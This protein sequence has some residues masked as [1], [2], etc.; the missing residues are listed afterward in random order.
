MNSFAALAAVAARAI[1][2]A[3]VLFVA[4]TDVDAA[5]RPNIV[6]LLADDLGGHD[7]GFRGGV[8]RTPHLDALAAGGAILNA[9]YVQPY[10]S[11][12][13]AALLTGRYPMRY[14]LQSLSLTRAS[15][16]GLPAEERTLAQSLKRSGY[17]TA[18]VGEWLLGHAQPDYWPTRRGFD[19]FYGSL[20]GT[21]ESV[22]RKG[23]RGDWRRGE[24]A[25]NDTGYVT[26]LL[27]RE[28]VALIQRH[29]ASVPLFLVVA[30]NAPARYADEP[31]AALDAYRDIADDTRRH[32]AA[33]VTGMDAAIGSIVRALEQRNLLGNSV[34]VFHSDNGGAVPMRFATGDDDVRN[35]A[36]D[37]GVFREGKGSLYEG[38]VRVAALVHWPGRIA[39]N[40]VVTDSVHVTDLHATLLGLAGAVA[41]PAH[42]LDGLDVW[43]VIAQGQRTP[44]KE[45][46][47][48]VDD[49]HGAI[50][51]GEWKLIAHAALPARIELFDIANDPQEAENQAAAYPDRV[52]DLLGRL[53]AH[54]YDMAPSLYLDALAPAASPALWRANPPRRY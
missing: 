44:R 40:T 8:L 37:N 24:R 49:F 7:V 45:L 6:Y 36:A 5:D 41:D 33:A 23:A 18:F 2:A 21:A 32:Y 39:P 12:T 14:G 47:L 50:R 30:F 16:Y 25:V 17:R 4:A 35:P 48:N 3:T 46:L 43:S 20:S 51:V 29:D 26:E 38:G 31:Q 1:V 19:T 13:Q 11:Q 10:S 42:P 27:A 15:G 52:Q 34:L 28:A 54:A 9:F 53:N 22:L